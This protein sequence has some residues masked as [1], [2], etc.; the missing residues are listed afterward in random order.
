[1]RALISLIVVLLLVGV[2]TGTAGA[3]V[4]TFECDSDPF[5]NG[6]R[7][8]GAITSGGAADTVLVPPC[9]MVLY[10]YW[11]IEFTWDTPVIMSVAGAEET[12]V[13]GDGTFASLA[14]S[15]EGGLLRVDGLTFR[16]LSEVLQRD[17][18]LFPTVHVELTN[19]IIEDCG[20]G[21]H[22]M[23]TT[24]ESFVRGNIIRNNGG[25]GINLCQNFGVIE[26]NEVY[27]NAGYG[28]WGGLDENPDIRGNHI[29]HNASGGVYLGFNADL[30]GN[31][32]E[33]NSV[34]GVCTDGTDGGLGTFRENV[35]RYN[36]VGVYYTGLQGFPGSRFSCNDIYDNETYGVVVDPWADSGFNATMNWWGTT[37][38]A[39]IA[40]AIHDCEDDPSIQI[41]VIFDPWCETPGC[42]GT[43]VEPSSWGTIKAL[44]R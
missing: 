2:L 22:A 8:F 25:A 41:C 27:G 12:V 7:L 11:P 42:G 30:I 35:I 23:W 18:W 29:H 5:V 32:I 24:D 9:Y 19:C 28:L 31:L 17:D 15:D 33:H 4:I 40:A 43:A 39:E 3:D 14:V 44:Y 1:M 16:G 26:D 6:G 20:D 36:A 37:D 13:E 10:Y 21:L 38:P 34:W